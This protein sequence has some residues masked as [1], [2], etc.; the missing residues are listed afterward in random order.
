[1]S[2]PSTSTVE[3]LAALAGIAV[4]DEAMA[5]RIATGARAAVDAVVA[6]RM[7]LRAVEESEDALF[8]S[9]PADY[10]ALL[11]S[12]AAAPGEPSSHG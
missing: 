1:M 6:A 3:A 10:L 11:E 2:G 8:G 4:D 5:V 9:E 7:S 12:L